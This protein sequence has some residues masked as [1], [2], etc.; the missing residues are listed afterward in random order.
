[1]DFFF[2]FLSSLFS[3]FLCSSTE[4]GNVINTNCSAA[5]TRQA[6][7]CKMSVE[8][9]KFIESQKK[10]GFEITVINRFRVSWVE[11]LICTNRKRYMEFQS[12]SW[13]SDLHGYKTYRWY[14]FLCTAMHLMYTS[15]PCSIKDVNFSW[16]SKTRRIDTLW[17]NNRFI[18][19]YRKVRSQNKYG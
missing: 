18:K 9:D 15:T 1:M 11:W 2:F 19:I 17:A 8:Y 14:P 13:H 6:L 4:G 3:S 5:H 7:C 10:L 16:L 12:P